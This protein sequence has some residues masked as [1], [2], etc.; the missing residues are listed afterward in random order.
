MRFVLIFLAVGCLFV[1]PA[2]AGCQGTH[3]TFCSKTFQ[4]RMA[5]DDPNGDNLAYIDGN[6]C[7]AGQT[8]A[9]CKDGQ[10]CPL[11][12]P[13]EPTPIKIVGVE[14]VVTY[15]RP[16]WAFAGNAWQADVMAA[17]GDQPRIMQWFPPGLSFEMPTA[18]TAGATHIDLH[19]AC[20][21]WPWWN[22]RR[23]WNKRR[24]VHFYYTVFYTI[25]D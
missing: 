2:H 15:G 12:R 20:D 1:A 10:H 23:W 24:W 9:H 16:T 17:L 14:L 19:V 13:W 18:G 21:A 7:P 8:C 6:H 22:H 3:H 4:A 25:S 11:I 5:C